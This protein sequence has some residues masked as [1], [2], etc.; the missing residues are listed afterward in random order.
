LSAVLVQDAELAAQRSVI[1]TPSWLVHCRLCPVACAG[2][3][4]PGLSDGQLPSL[5]AAHLGAYTALIDCCLRSPL[6]RK[7]EVLAAARLLS[8]AMDAVLGSVTALSSTAAVAGLASALTS[9]V[10]RAV[11]LTAASDWQGRLATTPAAAA[12]AA[13][14]SAEHSL[15]SDLGAMS[16]NL[17]AAV[18]SLFQ[19]CFLGF[20]PVQVES[21]ASLTS[22]SSSTSSS[23][24]QAAASYALLVVLMARSLLQLANAMEAAGPQLLFSALTAQATS[25]IAWSSDPNAAVVIEMKPFGDHVQSG[26]HGT[27]VQWQLML[28]NLFRMLHASLELLGMAP[29]TESRAA[30]AAAA[31]PTF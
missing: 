8:F 21:V 6:H 1:G 12:A 27:W 14:T 17:A 22:S 29:A 2:V 19:S 7:D 5:A 9:L 20:E 15:A 23:S 13:P 24:C 10:K 28:L 30:V 4:Q 26:V 25:R 16:A 11:Q 31:Q 18:P 3:A